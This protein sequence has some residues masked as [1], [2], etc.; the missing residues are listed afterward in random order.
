LVKIYHPDANGA[1]MKDM[2]NKINSAYEEVRKER[3]F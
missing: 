2:F 1:A 3:G